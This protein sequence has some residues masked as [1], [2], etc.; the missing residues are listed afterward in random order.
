MARKL[1]GLWVT[2]ALLL[3]AAAFGADAD[4]ETVIAGIEKRYAAPGFSAAFHQASTLKAMDITDTAD[5]RIFIQRPGRMRWEYERP[6]EQI[7]ITDGHQLW[8]YR[9]LDQQVM[10]GE[11]P[12]FFGG[13]KGAGFL[14]DIPSIRADFDVALESGGDPSVYTLRMTPRKQPAQLTAILLTVSKQTFQVDRVTTVNR[15]G[16]ETQIDLA[17]YRFDQRFEDA[18]FKFE[19]PPGVDV[20]QLE[21]E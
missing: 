6:E 5:G 4:L 21:A 18:F 7:I 17:D 11:A 14:S 20:L 1:I 3:A 19:V 12:A 8:M 9:P 15:Y 10:V 13:G 2:A 16:D